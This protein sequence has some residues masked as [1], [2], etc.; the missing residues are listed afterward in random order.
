MLDNREVDLNEYYPNLLTILEDKLFFFTVKEVKCVGTSFMILANDISDKSRFNALFKRLTSNKHDNIQ[1]EIDVVPKTQRLY[2]ADDNYAAALAVI[3]DSDFLQDSHKLQLLNSIKQQV[4]L[5]DYDVNSL[6]KNRIMITF[7]TRLDNVDYFEALAHIFADYYKIFGQVFIDL[8]Q[9]H[10]NGD[11]EVHQLC[12]HD[13]FLYKSQINDQN[14]IPPTD[15]DNAPTSRNAQNKSPFDD[16]KNSFYI[17][18]PVLQISL[19]IGIA[20]I[21]AIFHHFISKL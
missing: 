4:P 11:C 8:S 18:F 7:K 6:N 19:L 21:A 13:Y 12:P 14:D 20:I 2:T 9:L 10:T 17:N 15:T 3:N 5:N 16:R 1:F